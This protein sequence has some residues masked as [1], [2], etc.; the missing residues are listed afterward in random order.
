MALSPVSSMPGKLVP[1]AVL[2]TG[3][4]AGAGADTVPPRGSDPGAALGA[5]AVLSLPPP[6][7]PPPQAVTLAA[8]RAARLKSRRLMFSPVSYCRT[9]CG[10]DYGVV[11]L[12]LGLFVR[13]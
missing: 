2:A 3:T 8:A 10:R 5:G 7:P 9:R 4:G 1:I 12:R 13:S 6:P 11:Q